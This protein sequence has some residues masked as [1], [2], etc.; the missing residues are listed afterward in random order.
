ML[1]P[2]FDE[3]CE[4]LGSL[5]ELLELFD[6]K[7]GVLEV[8]SSL[9]PPLSLFATFFSASAILFSKSFFSSSDR[10]DVS[11]FFNSSNFSLI[12]L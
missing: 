6:V 1:V 11:I 4:E 8:T 10:L 2:L 12:I 3:V 9:D 7:F 5:D